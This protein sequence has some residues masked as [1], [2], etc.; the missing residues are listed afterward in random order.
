MALTKAEK[1]AEE[2]RFGSPLKRSELMGEETTSALTPALSPRRGRIIRRAWNYAMFRIV[3]C[4]PAID[5]ESVA[6][7]EIERF[8]AP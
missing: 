4:L 1:P 6:A 2:N 5:T 7:M 3:V 8:P